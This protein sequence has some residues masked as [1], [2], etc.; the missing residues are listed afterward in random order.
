MD[1]GLA[2]MRSWPKRADVLPGDESQFND[3]V[4]WCFLDLPVEGGGDHLQLGREGFSSRFQDGAC[5]GNEFVRVTLL[6]FGG[7]NFFDTLAMPS[8]TILDYKATVIGI[9][10][11][12]IF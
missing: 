8:A 5:R 4:Q 12:N 11:L 2:V 3:S 6:D 1:L 7:N 10:K 9:T